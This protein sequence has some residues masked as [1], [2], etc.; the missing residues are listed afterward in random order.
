MTPDLAAA[1]IKP[2]QRMLDFAEAQKQRVATSGDIV[3]DRQIFANVG[4]A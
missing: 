2:L 4:A 1:A 3:K